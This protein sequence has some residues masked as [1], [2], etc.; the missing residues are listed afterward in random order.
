[1][2]LFKLAIIALLKIYTT[3]KMF[4]KVCLKATIFP[5][6]SLLS[7]ERQGNLIFLVGV[8]SNR[9]GK[10]KC[11]SL[12]RDFSPN[13][14]PL[15]GYP[16]LPI[17]KTLRRV[18]VLLTATILKRL[19][20]CIFFQSNECIACKVKDEKEVE[21]YLMAFSLLKIIHPF[22]GKKHLRT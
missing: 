15:S 17:R 20:E 5:I 10:F 2:S 13:P 12:Q 4:G 8:I 7:G 1:M 6:C 9:R 11:L 18:L 16:N 21:N 22:Q 3:G 19:T 14:L